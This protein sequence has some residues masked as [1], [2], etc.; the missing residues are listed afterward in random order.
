MSG[1][2]T[3]VGTL[4]FTTGGGAG[5][6]DGDKGDVVVSSSG[7]VWTFDAAVVTTAGR[8]ILD[9][10]DATAQRA[11][12]GLGTIATAASGD[13]VLTSAFA[14]SVDD[15]V[16]ALLVAGS[17]I[18]L[19]YNDGAGTLTIAAAGGSGLTGTATVTV[20]NGSYEHTET[21]AAVGVTASSKVLL[22]LGTMVDADEN[23]PEMVDVATMGATPGTDTLS[24]QIAFHGPM[25]GA[26]PINWSAS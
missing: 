6:T 8:A 14:E 17:N 22:S 26:I 25:R 19:T 2:V 12:L 18:T 23:D 7:A 16:A 9:D 3:P 11:T 20:A 13:Y 24:I 4:A 21:V 10:A 5:I 15:R 1:V